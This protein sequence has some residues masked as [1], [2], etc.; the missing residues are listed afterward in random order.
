MPS[1]YGTDHSKILASRIKTLRASYNV[2]KETFKSSEKKQIFILPKTKVGYLVPIN[3]RFTIY[4]DDD[5][6]NTYI[7]KSKF[8]IKD[9]KSVYAFYILT[10]DD[11]TI[12]SI[13]SSCLN[14][15]LS[16][17][18]LKRYV[19]NL[20][21]LIRNE[22]NDEVNLSEKYGEYE[23]EPKKVIWV[24]PDLLYP[25][26]EILDLS[27]KTDFEKEE[28]IHKSHKKEFNLLITR[29]KYKEDEILGYCLRLTNL[30]QRRQNQE[31]LDIRMHFN[32]NKSLMYDMTKL[33]YMRTVLVNEKT[34]QPDISHFMNKS[35]ERTL[36]KTILSPL[37]HNKKRRKKGDEK[38]DE[39]EEKLLEEKALTKEKIQEFQA[40]N[41]DEIRGFINS[42]AFFGEGVALFKRDTEFKNSYE[43]HYNKIPLIKQSLEEFSKKM[44]IRKNNSLEK[45]ADKTNKNES[46]STASDANSNLEFVSDTSSSLNNIFNDKSV[47]NI[48]Y[49][50]F[51]VFVLLCTIISVE[52]FISLNI[53]Q[54]NNSRMF[55]ADKA[56]SILNSLLYTKFFLTEAVLAQDQN[57]NNVDFKNIVNGKRNNTEYILQMMKEMSQYHQ[58]ITDTNSF[59]SNATVNFGTDY[60]NYINNQQIFIRTLSNNI[61]SLEYA[62]FSNLI[63]RITTII[64]GLSNV[65]KNSDAFN[66]NNKGCY[67]LMMNLLNDY[68]LVWRKAT[69][70]LIQDVD[71]HTYGYNSL[72]I[73]FGISFAISLISILIIKKLIGKFVDD[74]EK[75]VDLF[76]TI[77]KVKFE[78]LKYSSEAFL[79]KLLNKFFGNEETEE[80]MLSDSAIKIKSDDINIAKFKQKNDYKQSIRTSSEY[81]LIFIKILIFFAIF[82]AYMTFKYVYITYSLKNINYFTTMFNDTQYCQSD[83]ILSLNTAKQYYFNSSIP[84]YNTT[85]TRKVFQ[86]NIIQISN[87]METMLKSTY[88]NS[89]YIG[90]DYL[91]QFMNLTNGNITVLLADV[92]SQTFL[93]TVYYVRLIFLF[94][95]I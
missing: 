93:D 66:M 38:S 27:R 32:D 74:R 11:F 68:L 70:L 1:I 25:K 2:H 35:P 5:F 67:E 34:H 64:F 14:L 52:F 81:L 20:N 60:N 89:K 95:G 73:I 31:N 48:K 21:L 23:E 3:A 54:N 24:F 9:T 37:K 75:P 45:K 56:Y 62:P 91:D 22:L 53:I 79:N 12:D 28:L 85:E 55:Y 10:K 78:E 6:S 33:N 4:N 13:S 29:I 69:F 7:I 46:N 40:K 61:P 90:S 87:Q 17:D 65:N 57:Y 71:N 92:E 84:I 18:L 44:A 41:S 26:N 51:F 30:D 47:T 36:E 58:N 77:K 15:N 88:T 86:N 59:F 94:L 50:S 82:Q 16:M 76:L 63:S 80:E 19:I 72:A 43:D 83:L 8:E 39:E 49:F 42:L